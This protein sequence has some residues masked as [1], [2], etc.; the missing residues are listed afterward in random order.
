VTVCNYYACVLPLPRQEEAM[1]IAGIDV[2]KKVFDGSGAGW[3]CAGREA[4]TA[5]ICHTAE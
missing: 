4:G 2:H 1:K 3:K 5:T